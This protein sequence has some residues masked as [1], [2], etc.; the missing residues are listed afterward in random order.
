M[1]SFHCHFKHETLVLAC[2]IVDSDTVVVG[3]TSVLC[4]LDNLS[5]FQPQ[6]ENRNAAE[7]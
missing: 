3:A 5:L 7:T 4:R 2:A 6:Q 1:M